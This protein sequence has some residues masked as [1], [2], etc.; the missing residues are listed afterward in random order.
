[1]IVTELAFYLSLVVYSIMYDMR[2]G[3]IYLCILLGYYV[4][5]L[6]LP[7]NGKE[8]SLRRKIQIASFSNLREGAVH[9]NH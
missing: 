9:Y 4:V 7:N 2:L 8:N 1:M 6:L 5:Y 3:V